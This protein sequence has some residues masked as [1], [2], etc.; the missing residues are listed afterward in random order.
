MEP[1]QV[2]ILEQHLSSPPHNIP[3]IT[4]SID[5]FYLSHRDQRLLATTHPTNR[6]I[7]HRGLP[8]THDLSL[9]ISVFDSLKAGRATSIPIYDK[10]A[11]GGLGDRV[12]EEKWERVNCADDHEVESERGV[13]RDT[14]T[15][16][17]EGH[18]EGTRDSKNKNVNIDNDHGGNKKEKVE[19][20]LFEGWCVA[21]KALEPTELQRRWERAV[22]A[23]RDKE[24][25]WRYTLDDLMFVN[26]RLRGYDVLT[27]SV[28]LHIHPFL[29][30]PFPFLF[31]IFFFVFAGLMREF[32]SFLS[33]RTRGKVVFGCRFFV[34]CQ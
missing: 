10:A 24:R 32:L 13:G 7:Q 4:L 31:Q 27:E 9:A 1:T 14:E 11:F 21:F 30:S 20:V 3:T 34:C 25:L 6:L 2:K 16:L 33:V 8:G 17:Q 5:D 19:I 29:P 26:E 23:K 18:G 12:D 15:P 28:P 22:Q